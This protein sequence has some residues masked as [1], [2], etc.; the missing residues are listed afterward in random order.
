MKRPVTDRTEGCA[1]STLAVLRVLLGVKLTHELSLLYTGQNRSGTELN[2][3]K[4]CGLATG[5]IPRGDIYSYWVSGM[6]FQERKSGE[7]CDL[8]LT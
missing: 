7:N 1:V 2:G 4:V 6:M 5:R 3:I 8:Y